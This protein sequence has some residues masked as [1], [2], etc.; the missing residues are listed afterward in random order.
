MVI[1]SPEEVDK[2]FMYRLDVRCSNN[3][4]EYEALI[5]SLKLLKSLNVQTVQIMGDSQLVIN[6]LGEYKCN[7]LMLEEYLKE[8]KGL[9]EHFANVIYRI[10]PRLLMKWKM[11]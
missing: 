3:Q 7:S 1:N 2:K 8:A 4:A 10:S 9:L 5:I 6:Q 11:I